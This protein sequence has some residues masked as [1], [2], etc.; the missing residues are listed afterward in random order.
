MNADEA[1]SL[2]EEEARSGA[3]VLPGHVLRFSE[4]H[5]RFFEIARSADV[6][7]ILSVTA[8]RDRDDSHAIRYSDDPVL[9]TMIHDIDLA[10]WITGRV[11]PRG[12]VASR[13]PRGTRRSQ[14]VM[15]TQGGSA[16]WRLSTAWTFHR[17]PA[18]RIG[19][20]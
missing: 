2:A 11:T 4:A 1:A 17:H 16:I 18:R 9:M 5:R 10:L 19:S 20:R 13:R 6:G 12:V 7:S 15:T 8:R 14:T 3:F